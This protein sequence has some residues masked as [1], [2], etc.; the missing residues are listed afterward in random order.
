[1]T[2]LRDV[3][4]RRIYLQEAWRFRGLN[5]SNVA[6]TSDGDWMVLVC[7]SKNREK[8]QLLQL[9]YAF[10][11]YDDNTAAQFDYYLKD[12]YIRLY[13][14]CK[15]TSGPYLEAE[16]CINIKPF[17]ISFVDCDTKLFY[18][19]KYYIYILDLCNSYRNTG[20]IGYIKGDTPC[21]TWSKLIFKLKIKKPIKYARLLALIDRDVILGIIFEK[22]NLPV[23]LRVTVPVN[24]DENYKIIRFKLKLPNN[25]SEFW[26]DPVGYKFELNESERKLANDAVGQFTGLEGNILEGSPSTMRVRAVR[27]SD[28]E[29]VD[30]EGKMWR[31]IRDACGEDYG[32][33]IIPKRIQRHLKKEDNFIKNYCFICNPDRYKKYKKNNKNKRPPWMKP[34]GY[35]NSKNKLKDLT[36]QLLFLNSKNNQWKQLRKICEKCGHAEEW[37]WKPPKKDENI[38]KKMENYEEM[39]KNLKIL[40]KND[41]IKERKRKLLKWLNTTDFGQSLKECED[42]EKKIKSKILLKMTHYDDTYKNKNSPLYKLRKYLLGKRI[43]SKNMNI[44]SN[45][46]NY[47]F[48][49]FRLHIHNNQNIIN[50][51]NSSNQSDNERWFFILFGVGHILLYEIKYQ[52]PF[53][54]NQEPFQKYLEP[55]QVFDLPRQLPDMYKLTPRGIEWSPNA[56]ELFIC[57]DQS[58]LRVR[59]T[60]TKDENKISKINPTINDILNEYNIG[61]MLSTAHIRSISCIWGRRGTVGPWG[62][63]SKDGFIWLVQTAI[64][65]K[66]CK[67]PSALHVMNLDSN[68]LQQSKGLGFKVLCLPSSRRISTSN[69]IFF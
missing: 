12:Y 11:K 19:G 9:Q 69:K 41:K 52:E 6:F 59:L 16:S 62:V 45:E 60:V 46:I 20:P 47:Y 2:S 61:I 15:G 35:I 1:M 5:I 18:A 13:S 21:S 34:W 43:I 36:N 38:L 53:Q 30:W 8:Y 10:E 4:T 67:L 63:A 65:V 50:H 32:G 48:E 26:K 25:I 49:F 68:S 58:I 17:I 54:K 42:S 23:I 55:F 24:K 27:W 3:G 57:T 22:S 33:L 14:N 51:S 39:S 37:Y 7:Q 44:L 31:R 56:P 64:P 28:L 40:K 29:S 66:G